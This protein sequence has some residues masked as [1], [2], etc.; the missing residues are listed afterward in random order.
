MS[1]LPLSEYSGCTSFFS[2]RS[3]KNT[4]INHNFRQNTEVRNKQKQ[5]KIANGTKTSYH[6]DFLTVF[7]KLSFHQPSEW[8]SKLCWAIKS[9]L[10]NMQ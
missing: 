3:G 4:V 8:R 9:S 2:K 6:D 10:G 5:Q 7:F 1:K